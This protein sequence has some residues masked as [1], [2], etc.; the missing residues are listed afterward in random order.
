[1]RRLEECPRNR[2]LGRARPSRGSRHEEPVD[3]WTDPALTD[4][5]RAQAQNSTQGRGGPFSMQVRSKTAVLLDQ[6]PMWLDALE[7]VLVGEGITSLRKLTRSEE[8]LAAISEQRPELFILDPYTKGAGPHGLDCLR[9]AVARAPLLK[10]IVMSISNDSEQIDSAFAAGAGAYVLKR[11]LPEDLAAAIRQTFSRSFYFNCRPAFASS[12][13]SVEPHDAGLTRRERE[14]LA[15]VAEGRT[16]GEVARALWVTEQ[17]VKFH[18][19]NIYRKLEVSN[20]TQA[21]R[22]AHTHGLLQSRDRG[23]ISKPVSAFAA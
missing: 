23:S 7:R 3:L 9:E 18:L 6:Q 15:Y 14:I 13:P 8:A 17:T 11:A 4:K 22:W 16:N 20:R 21:S 10:V 1:M 2:S 12:A 19:A 5:P